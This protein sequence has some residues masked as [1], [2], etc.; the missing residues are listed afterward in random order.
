[1]NEAKFWFLYKL[2]ANYYRI[3]KTI[4]DWNNNLTN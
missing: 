3:C 4:V 2:R 1:M